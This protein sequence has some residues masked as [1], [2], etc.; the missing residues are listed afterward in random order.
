MI[1]LCNEIPNLLS[2][3]NPLNRI[4]SPLPA[5]LHRWRGLLRSA[6]MNIPIK[7]RFFKH[8]KKTKTCWNWTGCKDNSDGRARF[9]VNGKTHNAARIAYRILIGN[10]PK[11]LFVLHK[12]DNP[13][14]V[15]PKH[16]FLGT[17]LDNVRD[18]N[19][20]GRNPRASQTHCKR[21][22]K[23]TP[24]NTYRTK[25]GSRGCETCWKILFKKINLKR[26]MERAS[27]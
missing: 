11:K 18:M 5:S 2:P 9:R 7:I 16:L 27:K 21:G 12:C 8:V 22:H 26:K 6:T 23:F 10:Y 13:S 3:A 15:N 25:S 17:P 20:K 1:S 14:C 4:T 19:R 24:E